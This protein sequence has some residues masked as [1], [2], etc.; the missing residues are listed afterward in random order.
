MYRKD[1]NDNSPLRV[2]ERSIHGGLGRGNIGLVVSRTGVGKT[3]FLVDIALD[4]LMRDRKVL[5]VSTEHSAEKVR[6]YYDEIFRDFAETIHLEERSR[7][8]VQIERNRMINSFLHGSFDLAKVETALTYMKEHG[9][10]EPYC[11]ILDGFPAWEGGSSEVIETQLQGL[12]RL[13]VSRNVE[14]WLSARLHREDVID[15]HGMPMRL[16][17]YLDPIS[18]V[19]GLAPES[20]HVKVRLIKDHENGNLAELHLELDP[21]TLLVKW[22]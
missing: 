10:F 9:H 4:D 5:H 11:V 3:A 7:I 16:R 17:P 1:V 2:F 6:E 20:D 21:R 19:V 15:M 12:K 14:L 22:E 8:R 18:V 13:A